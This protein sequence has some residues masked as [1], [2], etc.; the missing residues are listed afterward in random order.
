MSTDVSPP[1][2]LIR[3]RL[4]TSHID[5]LIDLTE[6]LH[7]EIRED[8]RPAL[9]GIRPIWPGTWIESDGDTCLTCTN[10]KE[11]SERVG[12]S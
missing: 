9:C 12:Q 10:V 1:T 7:P 8:Q 5:H 11:A 3:R 2:T 6:P 4:Y